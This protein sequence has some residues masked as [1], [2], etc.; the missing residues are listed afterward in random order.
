[1]ELSEFSGLIDEL[2]VEKQQIEKSLDEER[3]V[4][5]KQKE[6]LNETE[7]KLVVLKSSVDSELRSKDEEIEELRKAT[8]SKEEV[9]EELRKANSSKEEVMEELRKATSS[10]HTTFLSSS[11]LFSIC[12]FST[13]NSSINPLNSDNSILNLSFSDCIL[14]KLSSLPRI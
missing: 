9:I 6:T 14:F 7:E 12:C 5:C 4:V 11:K 1:M 2:K 13:F 8:S 10:N 3:N